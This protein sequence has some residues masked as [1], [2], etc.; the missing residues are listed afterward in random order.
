MFN[1]ESFLAFFIIIFSLLFSNLF[2]QIKFSDYFEDK[3]LRI[4]YY[5]GGNYNSEFF[6]IDELIEEEF[7]AGNKNNLI[8]PFDYGKYQILVKDKKENLVLYSYNYSTLFSEWQTIKEA[9]DIQRIFHETVLIPYPKKPV[10]VEFYSRDS[11][12]N[13]ILKFELDINPDDP[14]I[15]KER[16]NKYPTIPILN[17][18]NP[19]NKVDI[20]FIPEGYTKIDSSKLVEDA[21]RFAEYLFNSS[22]FKENKDN[23][24]INLVVAYSEESETDIPAENIWNNTLLNSRFYTFYLDR[25]LMTSDNKTLRNVASN[26]PYDQIYI[27]VNTD[28]YGG[29]AIYNHY[30]V[31]ISDNKF[32]EYVFIHEFGHSFAFLADEYYSSEVAYENFYRYDIEPLEPNITNLI[33]FDS[34]WKSMIDKQTPIPTPNSK[35][36]IN[37]VG[38]FEGGGY[39]SKGIYRPQFDC[40]MKS[41][42]VDNFCKV[43]KSAITKMINYYCQ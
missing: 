41:I 8:N 3:A 25:Y 14:Y 1:N 43:C 2:S 26:S 21:F 18:G 16:K 9:K 17:N 31:C 4:D 38:V 11:L 37:T 6:I 27:L 39:S 13:F 29:G 12:N 19:E 5:H 20:V 30:A 23:F 15:V 42:S 34:K 10:K 35:N 7:W 32:S 24:N 36:Y 22:P 33:N 28:Q 40:T